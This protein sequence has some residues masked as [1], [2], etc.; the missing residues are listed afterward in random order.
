V[1][2]VN[3]APELD[4]PLAEVRIDEDTTDT[5]IDLDK[6]FK[7]VDDTILTYSVTGNEK[8]EVTITL[9]GA[10]TIIP[11]PDWCGTEIVTF[12][13]TDP[14]DDDVS[15]DLI[16]IIEA[17]NDPPVIID[18]KKP[19]DEITIEY[20][21]TI[22][23][24]AEV[25]D[26]DLPY[27]DTLEYFWYDD[28][29]GFLADTLTADDIVLTPGEHI[30]EFTV[31]DENNTEVMKAITVTMKPNPVIVKPDD[32]PDPK[33]NGTDGGDGN[34]PK[35]SS[36]NDGFMSSGLLI[37]IILIVIIIIVVLTVLGLTM[38]KKKEKPEKPAGVTSP[39]L[40]AQQQPPMPPQMNMTEQ[41]MMQPG[42]QQNMYQQQIPP[43]QDMS[44]MHQ[45]P[46]QEQYPEQTAG[47]DQSQYS[48]YPPQDMQMTMDEQQQYS[49]FSESPQQYDQFPIQPQ[50]Y[51]QLPEANTGE[52]QI[53][54]ARGTQTQYQQTQMLPDEADL[55]N[56][57]QQA[58]GFSSISETPDPDQ[59]DG[60]G[61]TSS[62]LKPGITPDQ[63]KKD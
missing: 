43:P 47:Y 33:P 37:G 1:T 21:E 28:E 31:R 55:N 51:P 27:G 57:L 45:Y 60:S 14:W 30:I 20:N 63:M 42:M 58:S 54:G 24:E 6:W 17:V 53:D 16:V 52:T 34:D 41:S 32:K 39:E 12:T 25:D 23:L 35:D 44:M 36:T 2:P 5:S 26:K 15:T 46:P 40:V 50:Q 49:Q 48:Q 8:T 9:N 56:P 61:E 19:M 62:T 4:T 29:N 59:V 38:K 13:A 7:D 22:D 18:I 11:E 3:D 10:V